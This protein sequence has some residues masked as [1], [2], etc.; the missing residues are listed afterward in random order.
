MLITLE[1]LD[2]SGKTT[3]ANSIFNELV[4]LGL[5]KNFIFTR[6]PG[7]AGIIEAEKIREVILDSHSRLSNISEALL[8][9]A[10]RRIHIDRVIEPNYENKII[11]CDRYIDSFYA[12]QGYGRELGIKWTKDLTELVIG[13]YKP[14]LTIFI[15]IT[16]EETRNRREKR[17]TTDRLETQSQD[18]YKR[19]YE[20]YWKLINE[21][22]DRFLV[23]D[24]KL[25]VEEI[26]KIIMDKIK[27]LDKF[28]KMG[29]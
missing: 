25:S 11:I 21:D 13:K 4:G 2:G 15:D 5:E 26:V 19:T 27:T 16:Y 18:F 28:K 6:E 3:I 7:G 23:I 14:D 10:S 24:G 29:K 8:Y 20:G 22:R 9:S 12:Y 17:E 1:G